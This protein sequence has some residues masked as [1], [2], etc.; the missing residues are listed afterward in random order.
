[1]SIEAGQ[2]GLCVER[3][4]LKLGNFSLKADF[5]VKGA[6]RLGLIGPSGA[7]KSTLIA[8]LAGFVP[9]ASGSIIW[10]GQEISGLAPSRRPFGVMN[11]THNLF[12]HLG[13]RDNVAIGLRPDLRLEPDENARLDGLLEE[14][15]IA[16]RQTHLPRALSGGQAARAAIAR[17]LLQNRE[18]FL[19]DEPFA[20]LGPA[21][22]R[23]L[24][25]L[26]DRAGSGGA[27]LRASNRLIIC[28]SHQI[29]D[30][31]GWADEI[32][33]VENG[34]VTHFADAASLFKTPPNMIRDY[35]GDHMRQ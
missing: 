33:W 31:R 26:L 1:M 35:M 23:R 3:L 16:H 27:Q 24:F 5:R 6:T 18:I 14:L 2:N 28:A 25:A 13:L 22:R 7:G 17:C 9:I 12:T 34:H 29:D 11:Q 20:A 30:I 8:A 19:L 21:E 10:Q 4:S 32:L 15:G